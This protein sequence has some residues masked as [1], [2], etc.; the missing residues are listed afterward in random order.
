MKKQQYTLLI[1][2]KPVP[3]TKE[4]EEALNKIGF[5]RKAN[6]QRNQ[7]ASEADSDCNNMAVAKIFKTVTSS[8]Q[9]Y[10][11]KQTGNNSHR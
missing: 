8:K 5:E 7:R 9:K 6:G 3:M 1:N 4:R 10:N 11:Q 2:D